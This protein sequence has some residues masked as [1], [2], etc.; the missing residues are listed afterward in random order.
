[1]A[2]WRRF[3]TS[4]VYVTAYSLHA[5][6]YKIAAFQTK[7]GSRNRESPTNHFL[8]GAWEESPLDPETV[9]AEA[10]PK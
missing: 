3:A 2:R 8:A 10:I 6:A 4:H 5:T 9:A 7:I 1:M